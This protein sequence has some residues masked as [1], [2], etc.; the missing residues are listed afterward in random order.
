VV[1]HP[2]DAA[3]EVRKQRAQDCVWAFDENERFTAAL[4]QKEAAL[5]ADHL[6]LYLFGCARLALMLHL[7]SCLPRRPLRVYF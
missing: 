3:R 4:V 6:P 5:E 7:V 2:H 1:L